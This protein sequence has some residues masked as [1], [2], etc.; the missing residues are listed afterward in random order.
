MTF[1][2]SFIRQWRRHSLGLAL[3]ALSLLALLSVLTAVALTQASRGE[4]NALNMS[5]SLRMLSWR[6]AAAAFQDDAALQAAASEF[7]QRLG[8]LQTD[9]RH[10]ASGH[11]AADALATDITRAWH[12]RLRPL[13]QP[14]SGLQ[15]D[16]RSRALMAEM[17]GFVT[18]LDR[19]VHLIEQD[20][21]NKIRWLRIMLGALLLSMVLVAALTYARQEARV[22]EKTREIRQNH[23]SLQL[24]YRTASRLSEGEL[25]QEKLL[26]LLSDVEQE[27]G[28]GPGIIC[29][30]Q[31]EEERAYPLATRMPETQRAAL[32]DTL[33]C[34]IC[35]G[36]GGR[37]TS[38]NVHE[39][40]G[41]HL[42]S[43]PLTGGGQWQGV[44]PFQLQPGQALEPWQAQVLE[45]IGRHVAT[46]LA[47]TRRAEERHRLAVLEERSVIA[48]ELHDSIA[49]TLSYLKIQI[50]LLQSRLG[51]LP[52]P[53]DL[54]DTVEELKVGLGTAY[55]ELRELLTTFRLAPGQTPFTEELAQMVQELSRRCG[56]PIELE[57][58]MGS[59]QLSANEEIH[60]TSIIREAL[61]NIQRHAHAS[62]ARVSLTADTLRRVD[63][64]IEDDG[65]GIPDALPD[66]HHYGLTIMRDRAAIL[67]GQLRVTARPQGG[68]RVHLGF[69]ANTPYAQELK[70]S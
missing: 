43:V 54:L 11:D 41:L 18:R 13:T 38:I 63:V 4:A 33:G 59:M 66:R 55:S 14:G 5:G 8:T 9:A 20:L 48:R 51:A 7:E 64:L 3:A 23:H 37:L 53:D 24:L 62:W 17:P 1:S 39:M 46:A 36:G 25:T 12:E 57:Q 56:H 52:H 61:I 47:N 45:T 58:H 21:E 31:E 49:Q 32:C 27:L 19:L 30:R 28:L 2:N 67:Q 10:F 42:V 70:A 26:E 60:L 6:V 68:T 69:V 34:S 65:V 16:A 40:A 44:M 15:R 22:A 50:A 35:F 29:V